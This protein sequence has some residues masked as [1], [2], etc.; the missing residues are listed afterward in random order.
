MLPKWGRFGTAVKLNRGLKTSNYD[1]LYAYLKQ[2]EAHANENKMMLERYNQHVIDPLAFVSNVSPQQYPTQSST[3]PQSEYVPPVTH[4]P[5]FA[6][7]TQLDSGLTPTNDL[8]ENLTKIL[9]L[10]A[11][12]YKIHLPQTN[13]Q[14]RTSS[15][16][17]NHAIIQNDRVVVQN[18]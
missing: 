12:S 6:D 15:N 2:H 11:Q 8:I 18:V 16:T 3:I 1:Q 13:N 7:N 14:L 10:L 9:T 4:Q 17:R 5:Q